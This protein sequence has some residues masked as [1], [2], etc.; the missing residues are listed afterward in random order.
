M[1]PSADAHTSCILRIT[2]GL[3]HRI[4]LWPSFSKVYDVGCRLVLVAVSEVYGGTEIRGAIA[5]PR[6]SEVM[7][8][9]DHQRKQELRSKLFRHRPRF[10]YEVFVVRSVAI[11]SGNSCGTTG[12]TLQSFNGVPRDV[13]LNAG[14]PSPECHGPDR[15]AL[16]GGD[17]GA[18]A[19]AGAGENKQITS[20]LHRIDNQS[21]RLEGETE[22]C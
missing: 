6:S 12:A 13:N 21:T 16:D 19:G 2:Y 7:Q 22:T 4:V 11:L 14:T 1:S 18:R 8:A 10:Y 9:N 3:D 5:L 20:T 17:G 15:T